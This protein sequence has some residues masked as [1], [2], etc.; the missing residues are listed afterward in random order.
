MDMMEVIIVILALIGVYYLYKQWV[1]SYQDRQTQTYG[2]LK[3][4]ESIG[5]GFYPPSSAGAGWYTYRYVSE[6]SRI[7]LRYHGARKWPKPDMPL[8]LGYQ[9]WLDEEPRCKEYRY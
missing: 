8:S 1:T 9:V 2:V 5:V 7:E 6:G 3:K 4:L